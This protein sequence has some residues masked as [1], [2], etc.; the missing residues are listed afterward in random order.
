MSENLLELHETTGMDLEN[1]SYTAINEVSS[2]TSTRRYVSAKLH[3]YVSNK[4]V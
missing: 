3:Q 4:P 2:G 1:M